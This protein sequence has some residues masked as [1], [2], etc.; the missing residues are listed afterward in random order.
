MQ[1]HWIWMATPKPWSATSWP[2]VYPDPH[3]E[4]LPEPGQVPTLGTLHSHN[5][6]IGNHECPTGQLQE[7][8]T[9]PPKGTPYLQPT[10]TVYQKSPSGQSQAFWPVLSKG[11]PLLAEHHGGLSGVLCR[12]LAHAQASP[13]NR[14]PILEAQRAY[15]QQVPLAG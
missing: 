15:T 8:G 6:V 1:V 4:P 9:V 14:N 2:P 12:A 13:S 3:P 10:M 5:T 11:S 7:P